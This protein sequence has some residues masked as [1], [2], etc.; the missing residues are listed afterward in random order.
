L[1]DEIPKILVFHARISPDED[2]D[3]GLGADRRPFANR[4]APRQE[5][6]AIV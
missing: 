3:P 6:L 5:E 1:F 4:S 2:A